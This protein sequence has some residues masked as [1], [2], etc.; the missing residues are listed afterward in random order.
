MNQKVCFLRNSSNNSQNS[1]NIQS[2]IWANV[3]FL[4]IHILEEICRLFILS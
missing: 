2:L 3:F 1:K 4:F